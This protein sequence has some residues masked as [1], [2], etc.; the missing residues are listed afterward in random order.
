MEVIALQGNGSI[1]KS[2]VLK[3]FLAEILDKYS[4]NATTYDLLNVC[5]CGVLSKLELESEINNENVAKN[6]S[7]MVNNH[8]VTFGINN[9]KIG[10][11]T[12]GDTEWHIRQAIKCFKGC[13]IVFCAC[14]TRGKGCK[15]LKETYDSLIWVGKTY[16]KSKG[17]PL[18]SRLIEF[19]NKKQ[20]EILWE[21]FNMLLSKD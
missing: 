5:S 18:S 3:I 4:I 20:V 9:K 16:F 12:Y 11:T 17:S 14:R 10:L 15:Y 19:T 6:N 8:T 1:G 2:T 7:S 21:I 13:D